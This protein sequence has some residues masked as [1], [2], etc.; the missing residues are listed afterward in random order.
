MDAYF[1]Q[2]LTT[3]HLLNYGYVLFNKAEEAQRAVEAR[4]VGDGKNKILIRKFKKAD[5]S[6]SGSQPEENLQ[7][8]KATKLSKDR[9][10]ELLSLRE[11]KSLSR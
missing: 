6:G 5:A 3:G 4:R 1:I 9:P 10:E 11:R 7:V 8:Y 2:D